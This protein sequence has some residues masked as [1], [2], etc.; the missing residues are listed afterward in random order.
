MK[1][2]TT[3]RIRVDYADGTSREVCC[4]PAAL[5]ELCRGAVGYKPLDGGKHDVCCHTGAARRSG[6][7]ALHHDALTYDKVY[8]SLGRKARD[9]SSSQNAQCAARFPA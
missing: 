1:H 3:M 4:G 7:L 5:R 6:M 9:T 2:A 8:E